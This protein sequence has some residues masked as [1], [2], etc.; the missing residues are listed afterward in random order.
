MLSFSCRCNLFG[1]WA[2]N[3]EGLSLFVRFWNWNSFDCFPILR[4]SAFIQIFNILTKHFSDSCGYFVWICSALGPPDGLWH[5]SM[6]SIW[7]NLFQEKVWWDIPNDFIKHLRSIFL[8][9]FVD[10][11]FFCFHLFKIFFQNF[12]VR[13]FYFISAFL[14]TLLLFTS[15]CYLRVHWFFLENFFSII[16]KIVLAFVWVLRWFRYFFPK[17]FASLIG[18]REF[19]Q[20]HFNSIK[21]YVEGTLLNLRRAACLSLITFWHFF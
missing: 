5:L 17:S 3:F 16:Y 7:S 11:I 9:L 19:T 1:I 21:L 8:F 10:L 6:A 15:R 20:G 13:F 18:L 2:C 4:N 12:S 14:L